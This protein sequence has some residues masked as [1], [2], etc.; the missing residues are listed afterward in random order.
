ML[1]VRL[2]CVF[3]NNDAAMKDAVRVIIQNTVVELTAGAVRT[4]VLD[5]H[6]II[7]MLPA[8]ADEE[9]IDQALSAFAGQ[10]W[11]HVVSHQTSTKKHRMR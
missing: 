5:Q 9:A 6:V 2:L 4:S 11:V 8:I 10:D 7:E 3:M 1:G